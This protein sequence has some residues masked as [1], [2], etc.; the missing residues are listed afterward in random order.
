MASIQ[1]AGRTA[2]KGNSKPQKS[3]MEKKTH[4]V[5]YKVC[6]EAMESEEVFQKI[7]LTLF[8]KRWLLVALYL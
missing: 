5:D 6:R 1:A 3:S 2:T 8:W 7:L 4:T